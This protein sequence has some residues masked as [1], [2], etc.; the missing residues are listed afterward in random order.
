[1]KTYLELFLA[2]LKIG[3]FTFGGGYA[4]IPLIEKEVVVH[5][6]WVHKDE[7]INLFAIAQSIPGAIAINTSTLIGYKVA[8]RRGAIAATSGVILPSFVIIITIATFF[9]M[10]ADTPAVKAIFLGINGAVVA[11]ILMA[12]KKMIQSAVVDGMTLMIF[13]GTV[14]CVTLTNMSPIWVIVL[15]GVLG[16]VSY[17]QIRERKKPL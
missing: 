3:A 16:M 7:I 6:K 14:L 2:F 11:L 15:G 8:G 13:I 1:M 10:I 17:R 12:A 5:K 4:M 9:S